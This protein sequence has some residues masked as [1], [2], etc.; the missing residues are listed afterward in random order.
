[1]ERSICTIQGM[2]AYADSRGMRPNK[3]FKCRQRHSLPTLPLI[4]VKVRNHYL[5][6]DYVMPTRPRKTTVHVVEPAH[7]CLQCL[8]AARS[9]GFVRLIYIR[10]VLPF[11]KHL[12][13]WVF[14]ALLFD[15]FDLFVTI[16]KE[17]EDLELYTTNHHLVLGVWPGATTN[18]LRRQCRLLKAQWHPDKNRHAVRLA[19]QRFKIIGRSCDLLLDDAQWHR[20]VRW[21]WCDTGISLALFVL[22]LVLTYRSSI[23]KQSTTCATTRPTTI[24]DLDLPEEGSEGDSDF[25][26]SSCEDDGSACASSDEDGYS[27]DEQDGDTGSSDN[28]DRSSQGTAEDSEDDSTAASGESADERRVPSTMTKPPQIRITRKHNNKLLVTPNKVK[29]QAGIAK[30]S[31]SCR[32][33]P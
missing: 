22:A 6:S 14:K 29:S 28:T 3:T 27:G 32:D 16:V 11:W 23:P 9:T 26:P 4:A 7:P 33:L 17:M 19:A 24:L 13:Q 10:I 1:M 30:N 18:Q 25:V 5:L 21:Y 12:G 20:V 15:R 2:V 31:T 8:R